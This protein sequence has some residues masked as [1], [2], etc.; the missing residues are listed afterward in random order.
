MN[1]FLKKHREPILIALLLCGLYMVE[2]ANKE[3][4]HREYMKEIIRIDSTCTEIAR[5][6]QFVDSMHYSKCAFV[7]NENYLTD[8]DN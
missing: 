6:N 2:T 1:T 5:H 8:I 7:L 3:R 4:R